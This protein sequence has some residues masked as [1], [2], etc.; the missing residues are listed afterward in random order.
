MTRGRDGIN[1]PPERIGWIGGF[2]V[3]IELALR[4]VGVWPTVPRGHGSD[5]GTVLEW[6]F[7]S[8]ALVYTQRIC[9][10]LRASH[11][12]QQIDQYIVFLKSAGCNPAACDGGGGLAAAHASKEFSI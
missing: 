10:T 12:R 4:I 2:G 11:A 3:Y 9:T 1:C 8:A 6:L 7:H 5:A